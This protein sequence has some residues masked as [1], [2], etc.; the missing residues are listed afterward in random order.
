[1]I[2]ADKIITLRKKNNWSQEELAFQLGVSRQAVSKWES[3][4]SIPDLERILKMS[5][6]FGVS[7]DTLIK[8]DCVLS[9]ATVFEK[10]PFD[11]SMRVLT[12]EEAHDYLTLKEQGTPR[13]AS[14]IMLCI[15]AIV[16]AILSDL[17]SNQAVAEPLG[18]I[19]AGAFV[20]AG[21]T[22][23][24]LTALPLRAWEWLNEEPFE[25]AYGVTG[26]VRKRQNAL[27]PRLI[28]HIT[29]GV[30]LCILTLLCFIASDLLY[31]LTAMPL[32]VFVALGFVLVAFAVFLFVSVG[33]PHSAYQKLL[34][35]GDYTRSRKKNSR[36]IENVMGIY[37]LITIA[38]YLG[39]SFLTNDWE[40]SWIIWPIA[41]IL[42]G[43]LN[44][45]LE[46]ILESKERY[47]QK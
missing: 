38:L 33:I 39:Y 9:D 7:T 26:M 1:M 19:I 17:F 23:I 27:Q 45:V 2:L 14:G 40:H 30:A 37:W 22:L 12:L 16:P 29:I 8:D 36:K 11:P 28:M 4:Q 31:E 15:L 24:L 32:N 46:M 20:M 5:E 25:T 21:V 43:V 41:G 44:I 35:E 10:E 3:A 34:E 18:A 42:C 6:L 13:M 47:W